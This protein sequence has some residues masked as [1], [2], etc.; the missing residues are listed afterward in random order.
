VTKGKLTGARITVPTFR[1]VA[2]GSS[3]DAASARFTVHGA[4]AKARALASGQERRQ[5]GLKLRAQDGC[6]LVYVMWRLDP[7]PKLEVSVKQNP[8]ARTSKECGAEGYTKV[9]PQRT[10]ALP[11]LIDGTSHEL[12]AEI[13]GDRLIAWV[14]DQLAW[15]GRLPASASELFGPAGLRSDNLDFELDVLSAERAGA[16]A[17]AIACNGDEQSD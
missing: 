13:V 14:D 8:G 7:K 17:D 16:V 12:R 10:A 5:L 15:E 3:G 11:T 4:T 6:N 1:A 9:K 2:P